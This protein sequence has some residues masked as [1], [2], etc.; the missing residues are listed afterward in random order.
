MHCSPDQLV[1]QDDPGFVPDLALPGLDI[2]LSA[3]DILTTDSSRRSSIMSTYSQ[4]SS[5]S[6]HA[7]ADESMLGLIIPTSD[8]GGAGDIGGF[9]LPPENV[10]SAQRS[11][12]FGR[13]LDDEDEAFNIDPGFS[14]DADGNLIE[15]RP[16][17]A[18]DLAP[19]GALRIGSDSA[20]SSHV[21]RELLAGLEERQYE[22][23]LRSNYLFN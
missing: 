22:V 16:S 9:L 2:D 18:G 17:G 8:T 1:L 6:S 15:E 20:A 3:L 12:R 11:G 21:R 10:S 19:T 14:I 7:E 4:R 23:V 13:L 5:V